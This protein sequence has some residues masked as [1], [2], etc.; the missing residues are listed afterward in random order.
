MDLLERGRSLS[1]LGRTLR[2]SDV[3]AMLLHLPATSHSRR[4]LAPEAARAA[5]WTTPLML[6]L[7]QMYDAWE[8][9]AL[10][11]RG[12]E[13]SRLPARGV[14][15]RALGAGA[16]DEA[17]EVESTAPQPRRAPSASEIRAR[18]KALET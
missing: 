12:V 5:E 8:I 15:A 17:R 9:D 4:L 11:R 1:E 14:I 13:E 10:L 18:V 2:W 3:K 7:G 16:S 6:L